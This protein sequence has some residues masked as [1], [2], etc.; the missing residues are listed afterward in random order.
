MVSVPTTVDSV[1]N[2]S[3]SSNQRAASG[4]VRKSSI[5]KLRAFFEKSNLEPR[6]GS[7]VGGIGLG[8][9]SSVIGSAGDKKTRKSS[10]FRIKEASSRFYRSLETGVEDTETAVIFYSDCSL[11]FCIKST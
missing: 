3:T 11:F 1:T 10:S 9:L 5:L 4:L 7:G 6:G 8:G 2:A